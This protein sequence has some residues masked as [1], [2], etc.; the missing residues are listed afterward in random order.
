MADLSRRELIIGAAATVAAAALPAKA[1][2]T[3]WVLV[4]APL[5]KMIP[6]GRI[7]H[8]TAMIRI[9]SV[10]EIDDIEWIEERP[11]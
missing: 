1:V 6:V 4:D 10:G 3:E 5:P 8:W 9:D 2:P 7:F 11:V